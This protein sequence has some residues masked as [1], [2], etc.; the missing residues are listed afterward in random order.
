MI[1]SKKIQVLM[2]TG[3]T[4]A[5]HRPYINERI[6]TLLESTGRFSVKL[7]EEFRGASEETLE[8]YDLV[9]INYNGK[10]LI[11]DTAIRWGERAEKA[12]F[13]FVE[14]GKGVIVY[15]S[16][17]FVDDPDW[18]DEY[19]KLLGMYLCMEEGGR[20]NPK[21]DFVVH[22]DAKEHPITKGINES[23]MVINDDL[24]AGTSIHKDANIEVLASVFDDVENYRVPYF[25]SK[26]Q[27]TVVIPEGKLENMPGVN[28]MQPVIWTNRY[29]KGRVFAVSIGHE[30]ETIGRVE[31]VALFCRGAEW[32]A[33][34]KVTI[35]PPDRSGDNRLIP[36][37]YYTNK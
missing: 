5:E 2:I 1:N 33:T 17:L 21:G 6:R 18:P 30:M 4:T 25:P 37:P 20:R 22:L 36:W 24:F 10:A 14:S 31:F 35:D 23:W 26:H 34:G 19:K 28:K 27:P 12:L 11:T 32:A 8:P 9:F 16:S 13:N 29:G 15:H 3:L 7:I